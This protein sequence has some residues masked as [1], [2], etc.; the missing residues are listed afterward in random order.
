MDIVLS[1]TQH[2]RRTSSHLTSAMTPSPVAAGRHSGR[3]GHRAERAAGLSVRPQCA[4]VH[5][6]GLL[7]ERV[8]A[9]VDAD[10]GELP[11]NDGQAGAPAVGEDA[12]QV[13]GGVVPAL[14]RGAAAVRE[15]MSGYTAFRFPPGV[16]RHLAATSR[17][18]PAMIQKT[19]CASRLQHT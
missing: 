1:P 5:L 7:G 12:T 17:P 11:L 4:V 9:G 10:K 16:L 2:G 15:P 3:Y 18:E 14:P 8:Q 13:R 19:P 6:R